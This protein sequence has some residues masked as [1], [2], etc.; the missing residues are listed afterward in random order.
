[1]VVAEAEREKERGN[2]LL[3]EGKKDEAAEAYSAAIELDGSNHVYFSNRA[4]VYNLLGDF[5]SALADANRCVELKP[6]WAK[7][8]NRLAM[9]FQGL[10][11]QKKYEDA[12]AKWRELG[13]APAA[14]RSSGTSA[15]SATASGPSSLPDMLSKVQLGLRVFLV[16]NFALYVFPLT[17][18]YGAFQRALF[19]ACGVYMIH[20][21]R[22][23]GRPVRTQAYAQRIVTDYRSHYAMA[24]ML[25]AF[26]GS[27]RL[28]A[29]MPHLLSEIG[30][31]ADY[32]LTAQPQIAAQ[33]AP[34]LNTHVLPRFTQTPPEQWASLDLRS[35]WQRYNQVSMHYAAS[36]EVA[37]GLGLI[38]E[39]V[40]PSRSFLVLFAYWHFLRIRYMVSDD[41]KQTFRALDTKIASYASR[42]ATAMNLYGKIRTFA[43][44]MVQMPSQGQPAPGAGGLA[45]LASRCTIS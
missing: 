22:V 13:G 27:G 35:K 5:P 17:S 37:I 40:T 21:Y 3:R 20:L 39:L 14:T 30:Y 7:G 8:Y 26:S 1:M 28:I 10:G 4:H 29:L 36:L 16:L 2:S 19:S 32:V 23:H 41:I 33:L 31:V 12:L 6:D 11:D 9:A 43:G 44:S 42:N 18:S 15:A 24:A 34:P 38:V 45:G 25:F